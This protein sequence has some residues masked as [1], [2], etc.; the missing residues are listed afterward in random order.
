MGRVCLLT[1]RQEEPH[2]VTVEA[3]SLC[4]QASGRSL[5]EHLLAIA[6]RNE[7]PGH[8]VSGGD[9]DW[10]TDASGVPEGGLNGRESRHEHGER[11]E[12]F[13]MQFRCKTR[14]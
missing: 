3:I 7:R 4:T 2:S 10:H 13:M 8:P 11:R 6:R 5:V 1:A 12:H 14:G 9:A